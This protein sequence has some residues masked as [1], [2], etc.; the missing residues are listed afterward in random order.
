V[1]RLPLVAQKMKEIQTLLD[2]MFPFVK[3]LLK[4]YGEFYPVAASINCNGEVEQIL[5]E[6]DGENDFPTSNTVIGKLKKSLNWRKAEFQAITIFY[7]VTLKEEQTDAIAVFI[8]HKEENLTFTFYYPYKIVN[9][10]IVIT[11]PWRE[12]KEMEI[13]VN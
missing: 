5:I 6:E 9:E 4:D 10:V 11:E 3:S 2:T 1:A 7:D 8:E 13:F 12:N